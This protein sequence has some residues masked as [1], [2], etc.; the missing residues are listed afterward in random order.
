M[1]LSTIFQ[2]Y[3]G[4]GNQSTHR[5]PLTCY[6]ASKSG[7]EDTFLLITLKQKLMS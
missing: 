1:P 2:L 6:Y 3:R 4:G 7:R 5:K